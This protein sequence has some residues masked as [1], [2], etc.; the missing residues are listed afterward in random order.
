M[1]VTL[2]DLPLD[3]LGPSEKSVQYWDQDGELRIDPFR[4]T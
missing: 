4:A 3:F 1:V 2:G